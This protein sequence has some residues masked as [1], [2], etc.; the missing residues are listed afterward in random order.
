MCFTFFFF[1]EK[2]NIHFHER[3]L[4]FSQIVFFTYRFWVMWNSRESYRSLTEDWSER[5][6]CSQQQCRVS[7]HFENKWLER[8]DSSLEYL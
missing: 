2:D 5:A 1:M 6:D 3:T 4:P 7:V 8:N